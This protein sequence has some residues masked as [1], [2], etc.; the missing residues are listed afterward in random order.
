VLAGSVEFFE[1]R[2]RGSQTGASNFTA[3]ARAIANT[4]CRRSTAGGDKA[5]P[6]AVR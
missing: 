2:H 6:R 1:R 3:C 4:R 5:A